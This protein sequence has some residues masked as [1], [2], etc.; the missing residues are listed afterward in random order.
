MLSLKGQYPSRLSF[1][2]YFVI[3]PCAALA[4]TAEI[5]ATSLSSHQNLVEEWVQKA[6]SFITSKNKVWDDMENEVFY[7]QHTLV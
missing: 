4:P 3:V 7:K 2:R 5:A 1:G 6:E